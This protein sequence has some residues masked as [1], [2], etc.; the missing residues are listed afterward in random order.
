MITK[1]NRFKQFQ[2]RNK[3]ES[4]F[5]DHISHFETR[6]KISYQHTFAAIHLNIHCSKQIFIE[7]NSLICIHHNND[8]FTK[9]HQIV[10]KKTAASEKIYN[11]HVFEKSN[12]QT[13]RLFSLIIICFLKNTNT[14]QSFHEIKLQKRLI[15][16]DFYHTHQDF[17]VAYQKNFDL[18]SKYCSSETIFT[19]IIL[20]QFFR[21]FIFDF[22]SDTD[23][24]DLKVRVFV[25][26]V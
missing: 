20:N 6:R 16:R 3:S 26:F 8:S 9:F 10:Q 7:E 13:K 2:A 23:L 19:S 1:T 11:C 12:S 25:E 14:I 21:K 4:H 5:S 17:I 15:L 22:S 18:D 24:F